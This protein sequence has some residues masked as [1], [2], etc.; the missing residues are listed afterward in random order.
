MKKPRRA[1]GAPPLNIN[2]MMDM[3]TIILVFLLK[4]YSAE[5]IS[6]A[7]SDN[8]SLPFS[9]AEKAP[10]LAVN[11]VVEKGV[12]IVDG[13][14]V[15]QL[16]T[17]DDPSKPGQTMPSLPEEAVTGG[18]LI[19]ALFDVLQQKAADA[20]AL[21]DRAGGNADMGF[22]GQILLQVDRDMPFNVVRSVMYTAGQA[23]FGEFKF[24][25]VKLGD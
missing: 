25:V 14:P 23:Q 24:V 4:S 2:S 13:K 5:D 21:G 17:K 7:P 12:I 10:K 8:L 19:S 16:T 20:K 22:K 1:G 18:Q 11:L 9:T 3:M 6:V 15:L